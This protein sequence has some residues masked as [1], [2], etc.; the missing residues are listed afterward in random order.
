MELSP[1][2]VYD[3]ATYGEGDEYGNEPARS[4]PGAAGAMSVSDDVTTAAASVCSHLP[5]CVEAIMRRLY[6]WLAA[7][8][9]G[10]GGRGSGG[11]A[12]RAALVAL[13]QELAATEVE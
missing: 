3:G 13:L 6:P 9:G 4:R 5:L 8:Y 12:A 7:Q 10:G 11:V 1:A 2:Q